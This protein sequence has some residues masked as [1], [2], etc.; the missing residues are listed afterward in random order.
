MESAKL[1][2]PCKVVVDGRELVL[3][4]SKDGR[5]HVFDIRCP[6]NGVRLSL[7]SVAGELLVCAGHGWSFGAGGRCHWTPPGHRFDDTCNAVAHN[8]WE[9]DGQVWVELGTPP[10]SS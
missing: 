2:F 9:F 1:R 7:G 4:R 6:H 10:P 8:A 3:W 5:V